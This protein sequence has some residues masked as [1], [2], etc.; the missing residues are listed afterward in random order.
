MCL[1]ELLLSLLLRLLKRSFSRLQ[2]LLQLLDLL[3]LGRQRV[4]Q[5]LHIR[6]R[7]GRWGSSLDGLFSVR[8][9]DSCRRSLSHRGGRQQQ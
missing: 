9:G 7:H 8:S 4:F 1:L 5:G 6:S 3:L 2:L